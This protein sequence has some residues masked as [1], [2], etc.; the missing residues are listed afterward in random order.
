[1]TPDAFATLELERRFKNELLLARQVTHKHVVRIHDLGEIHGIKY[2]TMPFVEGDD[3]ATVIRR[4]GTLG[5]ARSL[6]LARQIAAGL[7]AAHEAAV[8][9]RDLKPANI[10]VGAAGDDD[11]ALIMDFG[12]ARSTAGPEQGASAGIAGTLEY[13]APE[14]T[15]VGVVDQR[16]D[17]YAFGLILYE[18]LV[19]RR[20]P[21]GTGTALDDMKARI[22]TGVPNLRSISAEMP[23]TVDHIVSTCLQIDPANRYQTSTELLAALNRIDDQGERIP[24]ARRLTRRLVVAASVVVAVLLGGMYV[25]GRRAAPG[26]AVEHEPVPVL[27]ADFDN[28]SGDPAFEGAVEQAL[29]TALEGAPYITVFKTADARAIAADLAPGKSTRIT[30]EVGQLIA[31]REGIKVVVGGAIDKQGAGYRLQLLATDPANNK[32]IATASQNVRDKAQVLT[33]MA[34]MAISVREALGESKTE[35][36]KVAAAE[37]VT[38]GSLDAMRAYAR[39]QE[40]LTSSKFPE[41]LEEYQRAVTLDPRF[42]RAYAGIAGVY[43]NYFKQPDKVEENYQAAMKNLD[44][45]TD[46]EKYRTLGTYYM[47]VARNY[48][49][50]I[51]NYQE[52]VRR[53]P[54]DDGGHGNLGIAYLLVGNLPGAVTEVRKSL[55][56]YPRNSLQRYNYAMYSMYAGNFPTAI[57]EAARVQKENPTLEYAWLPFALSKLAQDDVTASHDAYARMAGMSAFGASFAGLGEGDLDLYFGR[58]R[59]AVRVLRE[60]LAADAKGK[61]SDEMKARKYVALAEANLALGQRPRAADAANEAA[62]L[63]R[64]EGTRF[65]AARVLLHAGQEQKALQIA[66]D[67]E[68]MLQRQT[69]A[70]AR[71]IS[72]EVALEHGR[73]LEGIEAFRDAQKR[74]DSWFSRYLLGKA[75]VEAGPTHS[76]EALAE[77]DLCVKRRGEAADVFFADMPTL[78][79]LPPAYYWLARAQE[80]VGTTALARQN[81]DLFLKLRADADPRDPLAE[82][83]A[84]R[85]RGLP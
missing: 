60:G 26:P 53:Y 39:G 79:Y 38:A 71:L 36:A 11:Q 30:Q 1:V 77:L 72:G 41:A 16:V 12:I 22:E 49:Q 6:K 43:A 44:R 67:L 17:V 52:L 46:R 23:E 25:V 63:S 73:L 61:I 51:E 54:A 20:K 29:A 65:A 66:A 47:D 37:T 64:H 48:D 32:P 85:V 5:L 62:R 34:S 57:T 24:E 21:S 35:M 75:Y 76:A 3:L 84:R 7:E 50:A 82:D 81:Y 56:I 80:G 13:M 45:M 69:T 8:V 70:Y 31:R 14:Q 2:I 59:D 10:M 28:R 33:T 15:K 55:E 42:G 83:A 27:V 74:H 19:G 58:T 68:K 18:M 9:H 4:E 40:L 78:R